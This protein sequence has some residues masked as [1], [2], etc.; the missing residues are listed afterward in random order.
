MKKKLIAIGAS[1]MVASGI[2]T[3]CSKSDNSSNSSNSPSSSRQQ[4]SQVLTSSSQSGTAS[5][6]NSSASSSSIVTSSSN[7]ASTPQNPNQEQNV[8]NL[9]AI[10]AQYYDNSSYSDYYTE[11]NSAIPGQWQNYGIGDPF[12]MRWNGVYYMYVSTENWSNGVIAWKSTDLVNWTQ[13]QGEGLALGY[14]CEDD[15]IGRCAYAPEVFYHDGTFYM[16]TSP[17]GEGHYILSSKSPEGPFTLVNDTNYQMRIDGSVF[18]DD[19]EQMYFLHADHGGIKIVHMNSPT[20]FGASMALSSSTMGGWTEGPG[21]FK[22]NGIYYLTYTGSNVVSDAYR[23][24][25]STSD[26]G[27]SN[28]SSWKVGDNTTL[29]IKTQTEKSQLDPSSMGVGHSSTVVG[30]DLDSHYLAYHILNTSKGPNRSFALDRMIFNGSQISSSV[31]DTKS[32]KPTLPEFYTTNTNQ[33]ANGCSLLTQDGKIL[34]NK[35]TGDCFSAEFNYKGENTN[36]IVSYQDN[37][38]YIYATVNL[39]QKQ[40]TL[41][42]VSNSTTSL[43]A[44]S[45]LVNEYSSTALHTV[46]IAYNSGKMDLYFDN[47]C[48]IENAQIEAEGG[49]IG[50]ENAQEIFSTVFSNVAKGESDKQE[51]KQAVNNIGSSTYEQAYSSLNNST[52]SEVTSSISGRLYDR[53]LLLNLANGDWA[54]YKLNF[55]QSGKYGLVMTYNKSSVGKKIKVQIGNTSQTITLPNIDTDSTNYTYFTSLISKVTASSGAARVAIQA[56]DSGVNFISFRFEKILDQNYTFSSDLS[57]LTQGT[58]ANEWAI[59]SDNGTSVHKG[60]SDSKNLL[61]IGDKGFTNFS[62]EV[63][64]KLS[65]NNSKAGFLIRAKNYT[66]FIHDPYNFVQ[67]YFVY[68]Q[69][70]DLGIDVCVD[71]L[72]YAINSVYG[73]GYNN[74]TAT[75]EYLTLRVETLGNVI[76]VFVNG[77]WLVF[78]GDTEPYT[79]GRIGLYSTSSTPTFKDLTIT[80][81]V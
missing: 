9:P 64:I 15:R 37:G 25:Y 13:C 7:S 33:G 59:S 23:I 26:I 76:N 28:N 4:S 68:L 70:T 38:N 40:I 79:S 75:D 19:D 32:V 72:D 71:K 77:E 5:S 44:T 58:Y 48:K 18:M 12:V 10:S 54:T 43:I 49:K 57:S 31:I 47:K 81:T 53:A 63:K 17:R 73:V 62:A 50:Y 8:L 78:Y 29:L 60:T 22:R 80:E 41:N 27:P 6:Q 55:R 3:G 69:R 35:S 20:E 66:T 1:I 30:P 16:Y 34:S 74:I 51:V 52:L 11:N 14:V 65:D 56:L 39:N 46:K 45:S 67:G 36:F 42:K 24:Y 21:I 2:L 61:Y